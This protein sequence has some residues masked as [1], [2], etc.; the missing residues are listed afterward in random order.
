MCASFTAD[1]IAKHGILHPQTW[2]LAPLLVAFEGADY[3]L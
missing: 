1:N 3:D 2:P